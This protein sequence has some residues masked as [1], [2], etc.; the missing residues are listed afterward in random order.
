M[1][2]G[3]YMIPV[4]GLFLYILGHFDAQ[5]SI[6]REKIYTIIFERRI[7]KINI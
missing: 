5:I 3:S 4:K 1:T 2:G 6:V 7:F